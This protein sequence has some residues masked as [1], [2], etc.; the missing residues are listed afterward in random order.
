LED[1]F[2]LKHR[3]EEGARPQTQA[4]NRKKKYI[5]KAEI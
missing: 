3:K 1:A 2:I 5:E 4:Q